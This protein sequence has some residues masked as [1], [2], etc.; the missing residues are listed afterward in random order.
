[1]DRIEYILIALLC[2]CIGALIGAKRERAGEGALL[3]LFLGPLG[4]LAAMLL[5]PSGP[6]CPHCGGV[7]QGGFSVCKHCGR[8]FTPFP[9]KSYRFLERADIA[10]WWLASR[11][12]IIGGG[13]ALL[14]AVLAGIGWGA[15]RSGAEQE[16]LVQREKERQQ[17]LAE[18]ER[19][20]VARE[21]QEITRKQ[22]EKEM[23]DRAERERQ[24]QAAAAQAQVEATEAQQKAAGIREQE[25]RQKQQ[26][27]SFAE[28]AKRD[29]TELSAWV[30]RNRAALPLLIRN[31]KLIDSGLLSSDQQVRRQA[32][33][34]LR[35]AYAAYVTKAVTVPPEPAGRWAKAMDEAIRQASWQCDHGNFVYARYLL[36]TAQPHIRELNKF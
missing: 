19:A 22:Q 10:A 21:Q 12:W 16:M 5:Y 7:V 4:W 13:V 31:L 27:A 25:E 30:P 29:A 18:K 2:A 20:K 8:D 26:Q 15:Y 9:V 17:A 24:E 3:G 14:V 33:S 35:T 1:M 23:A 36:E 28:K 32:C 11:R 34:D 6:A